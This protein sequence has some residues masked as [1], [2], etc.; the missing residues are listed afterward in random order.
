MN[1]SLLSRGL[2][3][4]LQ[5]EVASFIEAN[6]SLSPEF[7]EVIRGGLSRDN[8]EMAL[9]AAENLEDFKVLNEMAVRGS[10]SGERSTAI[11]RK[12]SSRSSVLVA[13]AD[14]PI[15]LIAIMSLS[16]F[17]ERAF[18]AAIERA[19]EL[20]SDGRFNKAVVR[21]VVG[22]AV[23]HSRISPAVAASLIKDKS[24]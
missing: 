6:I 7:S 3:E 10:F 1:S 18:V 16:P 20:I 24:A 11:W 5:M 17:G 4:D 21:K 12:W 8:F 15:E 13:S 9:D 23:Y 22:W 14:H 19:V 2:G